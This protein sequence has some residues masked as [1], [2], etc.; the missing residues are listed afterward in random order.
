MITPCPFQSVKKGKIF[1]LTRMRDH[2]FHSF[3]KAFDAFF[4][5]RLIHRGVTQAHGGDFVRMVF[6]S[7]KRI[8][9]KDADIVLYAC[10]KKF[11]GGDFFG[12]GGPQEHA[13]K[14]VR[15][16]DF[17][18]KIVR[19]GFYHRLFLAFVARDDT[20]DMRVKVIV[21]DEIVND[22]LRESVGEKVRSFLGDHDL[23]F[24]A[25]RHDHPSYAERRHGYF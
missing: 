16:A 1:C 25:V 18:R 11:H 14:R 2:A 17:L 8:A 20:G 23:F 13:A 15:R 6:F 21:R 9:R 7:I 5:R 19:H 22:A 12:H 4:N 10:F 3:A 24:H